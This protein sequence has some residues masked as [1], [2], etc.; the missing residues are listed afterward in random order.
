MI[1]NALH[2]QQ[3]SKFR[4]SIALYNRRGCVRVYAKRRC[5]RRDLG[6]WRQRASEW[7][8]PELLHRAAECGVDIGG[9]IV[10]GRCRN[11]QA[12]N[13]APQR[14]TLWIFLTGN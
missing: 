2:H 7:D 12:T 8:L 14:T 1:P 3:S 9:A 10:L 6:E 13:L 11:K 5:P 4:R